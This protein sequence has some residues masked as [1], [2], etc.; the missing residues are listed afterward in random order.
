[1][2][3]GLALHSGSE[4]LENSVS[5]VFVSIDRDIYRLVDRVHELPPFES[6]LPD[7][8]VRLNL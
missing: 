8:P 1:M 3:I 2:L 7:H 5:V 4:K 6:E